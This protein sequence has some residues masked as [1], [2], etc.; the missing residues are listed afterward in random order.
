[1][2]NFNII[3]RST[4]VFYKWP[5]SFQVS[6]KKI[7]FMHFSALKSVPPTCCIHLILGDFITR[8]IFSEEQ[9]LSSSTPYSVSQLPV[10]YLQ[11]FSL[12]KYSRRISACII[13]L[14]RETKVHIRIV[15]KAKL[16]ECFSN[17]HIFT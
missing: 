2:V 4:H 10:T 16:F 7:L 17:V 13:S 12:A 5:L 14:I 8:I 9:K 6:P 15:Q 1:M 3:I 11:T